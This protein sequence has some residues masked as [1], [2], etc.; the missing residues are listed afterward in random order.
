MPRPI[1][2]A[3]AVLSALACAS[4][5][6]PRGV[7]SPPPRTDLVRACGERD[8]WS[9]PAPPAHV[10]ANVWYVG[11]CGITVLLV[12]SPAGH[13][14]IDGATAEAAPSILA[15]IRAAG[16]DPRDVRWIAMTHEHNDHVGGLAALKAATGAKLA[17]GAVAARALAAGQVS[18]EDP[19]HAIHA[20]FPP[21]AVDRLL[22]DGETLPLGP[23]RLTMRLNPVHSPGSASWTWSSRGADG[24]AQAF[25]YADSLTTISADDY[26]FTG[27][28][29]RV[30]A[31]RAGLDKVPV[32][33]CGILMTPHPG[34]SDMFERLAGR[35]P[36]IDDA[37]C[38]AYVDRARDRFAQRLAKE[39]AP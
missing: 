17:A 38:R 18:S 3:L 30:A 14:L 13:V 8:G 37:A 7:G 1:V 22:A 23:L 27:H 15:N 5:V 6:A 33:P 25:T 31:I 35:A 11:T 21:V 19:Q 39:A 2:A 34:A 9:D 26:R 28:P 16:F 20:A 4:C 24:K 36:L 10:A 29:A 12:T 32:S